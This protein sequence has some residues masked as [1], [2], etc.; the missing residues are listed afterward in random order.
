MIARL[1]RLNWNPR[2]TPLPLLLLALLALPACHLEG[3][4]RDRAAEE[5]VAQARQLLEQGLTDEALAAFEEA[6]A[7]NPD[8]TD[9]QIG[10]A[11][12]YEDR[13]NLTEARQRYEQA[14]ETDPNNFTAHYKLGLM[15]QLLGDIRDAI[16]TYLEAVAIDP[17]NF[18]VNRDLAAAYL[19]LNRPA[20]ALPYAERAVELDATSRQAWSNLAATYSFLGRYQDAVNTYRQAAEL[21]D[22]AD[23]VLLGLADAHIKLG[24]YQRAVNTLEVLIR[25][26]PSS[27]AYER[28][29]Y[30]NYKL[31]RFEDALDSFEKALESDP[32]DTAAL[33]GVGVALMTLYIE[34][35]RE[36]AAMRDRAVDAWRKSLRI[37]RNQP[38]IIELL[39]RYGRL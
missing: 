38:R 5:K 37:D 19:Q 17:D 16:R 13:G 27:T 1:H 2:I 34:G 3:G 26:S 28:L 22:L 36:E 32:R 6:L 35:E 10:A 33:N 4:R 21:G 14:A 18:A 7:E 9:A 25:R 23:P 15:Q 8:L 30:A 31:R 12:I 39:T 11:A 29:G 20:E 24:N